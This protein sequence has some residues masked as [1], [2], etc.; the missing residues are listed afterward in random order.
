[1]LPTERLGKGLALHRREQFACRKRRMA[2]EAGSTMVWTDVDSS[3]FGIIFS[4][5]GAP[6]KSSLLGGDR[7]RDPRAARRDRGGRSDL[8]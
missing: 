6:G 7:E 3:G 1:M 4:A 8:A 2:A 5:R